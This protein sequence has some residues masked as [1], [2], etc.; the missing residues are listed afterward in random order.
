MLT[1]SN[2]EL[3]CCDCTYVS[4]SPITVLINKYNTANSC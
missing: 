3:K 2:S 1:N 4:L